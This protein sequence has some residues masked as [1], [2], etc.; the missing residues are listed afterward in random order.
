MSVWNYRVLQSLDGSE[1][2]VAEVYY[3]GEALS[4]V[5]SRDYLR[6]DGYGDLKATVQLISKA[7]D[8]P[9]LRVQEGDR[10]VEIEGT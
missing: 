7:F 9:L 3:D 8:K 5:D 2:F 6:W 10:L 4:W 1:Y